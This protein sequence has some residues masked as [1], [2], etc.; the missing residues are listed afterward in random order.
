MANSTFNLSFW[1]RGKPMWG[2]WANCY[3]SAQLQASTIPQNFEWR[4]SVKQLQKYG[5]RKFGSRTPGRT[6]ARP[7]V[8]TIPLQ[9]EGLRGKNGLFVFKSQRWVFVRV[10]FTISAALV[11]ARARC[12]TAITWTS[13]QWRHNGHDSVSNHQP[14]HCLLSRLFRHRSKKNSKLTVT[15]LCAGNSPVTGDFPAQRARNAENVSIWWLNHVWWRK[16]H[17]ASSCHNKSR[18]RKKNWS[19]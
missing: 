18:Q 2:K 12:W 1:P 13:L 16:R 9:P 19:L 8:T 10:K 15:G 6:P 11:Q 4:K 3:E 7:T 14:Y 17:M 5:F